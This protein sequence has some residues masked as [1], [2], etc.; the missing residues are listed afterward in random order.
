MHNLKINSLD[1]ARQLALDMQKQKSAFQSPFLTG[2]PYAYYELTTKIIRC[3]EIP[4]QG[5][6]NECVISDPNRSKYFSITFK[7]IHCPDKN[8]LRPYKH[9]MTFETLKSESIEK[10]E[11]TPDKTLFYSS[12]FYTNEN[13]LLFV[14][15]WLRAHFDETTLLSVIGEEPLELYLSNYQKKFLESQENEWEKTAHLLRFCEIKEDVRVIALI[16][17]L[18][19]HPELSYSS[20]EELGLATP[21]ISLMYTW[22]NDGLMR[23]LAQ[24]IDYTFS[25]EVRFPKGPTN[26]NNEQIFSLKA[27][28]YLWEETDLKEVVKKG[29]RRQGKFYRNYFLQLIAL[30][31]RDFYGRID[32]TVEEQKSVDFLGEPIKYMLFKRTFSTP[33]FD[34][35]VSFHPIITTDSN[36]QEFLDFE[37]FMHYRPVIQDRSQK[38]AWTWH[39]VL[40]SLGK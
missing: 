32:A 37:M 30:F 22:F 35:F 33:E 28:G 11:I 23:R 7:P 18:D 9:L 38:T 2:R 16:H 1:E 36:D 4:Y 20:K 40:E 24:R 26:Q 19:L 14:C 27:F 15:N 13:P 21:F 29:A 31:G 3:P 5:I 8:D 25:E 12:D 17:P 39:H 34:L 6:F 10:H